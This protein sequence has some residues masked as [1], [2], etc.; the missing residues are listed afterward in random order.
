MRLMPAILLLSVFS[1]GLAQEKTKIAVMDLKALEGV[2]SQVAVS[3]TNF[4]CTAVSH[5]GK[6][7]VIG[8]D[9]MLT[10]LE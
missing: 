1:L 4:L 8:R 3:L 2:N 9:D 10:M 7:D 5:L 6:Y